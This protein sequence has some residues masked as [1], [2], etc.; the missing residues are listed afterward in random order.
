MND[1]AQFSCRVPFQNPQGIFMS[2]PD[3]ENHRL[4]QPPIQI[5]LIEEPDVLH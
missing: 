2:I 1:T 3:M 4:L 5:Q